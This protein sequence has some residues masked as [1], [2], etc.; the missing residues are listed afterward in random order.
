[1]NNARIVSSGS[2]FAAALAAMLTCISSRAADT[3]EP[4]AGTWRIE[5]FTDTDAAGKTS[6]PYGEH[7]KGYI[8]YDASGHVHVQIM[9]MPATAPFA[10]G[11]DAKGT[12]EEV[13]AAY[14]GYV[15]YF[16]TYRID[17]QKG[18]V[19]HRIEGS[20]MPSYLGTDQPRPFRIEGDVLTIEGDGGGVHFLRQLRRVR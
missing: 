5:R 15:A 19:V 18:L 9:R 8:V 3:V 6:Y 16:G 11:D 7:P 17:A 20:L 13:R 14:R 10:S 1:V 4:L 2:F 12:N